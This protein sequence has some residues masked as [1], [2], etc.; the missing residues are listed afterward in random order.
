MIQHHLSKTA[1]HDVGSVHISFLSHSLCPQDAC[2]YY[3]CFIFD[4]VAP[5]E[6]I[7]TFILCAFP[8]AHI[9]LPKLSCVGYKTYVY[10]HTNADGHALLSQYCVFLK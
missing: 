10:F 7:P 2:Q 6:N 4:G 8:C 5:E 3:S 9:K 1:T